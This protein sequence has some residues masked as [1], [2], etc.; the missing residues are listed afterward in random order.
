MT[1]GR[2]VARVVACTAAPAHTREVL[3]AYDVGYRAGVASER[4]RWRAQIRALVEY[5]EHAAETAE[6]PMTL[7][8]EEMQT[9]AE[10]AFSERVA[11]LLDDEEGDE[12]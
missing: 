11:E 9:F 7:T 10:I 8:P 3:A 6:Q 12:Q 2:R 4:A 5:A 1:P